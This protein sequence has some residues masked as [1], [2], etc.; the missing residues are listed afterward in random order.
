MAEKAIVFIDGA[1]LYK[2]RTALFSKLGEEARQQR[3]K[4]LQFRDGLRLLDL[5]IRRL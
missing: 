2:C 1:W 3:S 5:C 4:L